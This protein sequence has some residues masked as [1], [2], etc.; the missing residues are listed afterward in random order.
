M[1]KTFPLVILLI[2]FL[3]ACGGGG[4]E[5]EISEIDNPKLV[6]VAFFEA[7]YNEKDINK[8]ASVCSPKLARLLLHYKTSQSVARH[9]FNMSFEKVTEIKPD[10]TGVKVRERFK[11]KAVVTVY[12]EGFYDESKIKDVKRLLLIQNDDDQWVIDEILKDP[13]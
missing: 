13:F 1:Y 9:L 6:A 11:D 5:E 12:L 8:A 4:E 10:D 2:L 3:S 7:I